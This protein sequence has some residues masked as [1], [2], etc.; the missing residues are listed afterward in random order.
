MGLQWYPH[1]PGD[2]QRD[3]KDLTL[4]EHGAYRQLL[5]YYYSTGPLPASYDQSSDPSLDIPDHHRLYRICGAITQQEQKAVDTVV[6]KYFKKDGVMYRNKKADQVIEERQK[7]IDAKRRAVE[8]REAKKKSRDK[9]SD[10]SH[11]QPHDASTTTT[12]TD[13]IIEVDKST[14]TANHLKDAVDIWND[15]AKKMGLSQVQK[16]T[17]QRK[18]KLNARL[19]SCGGLDG[20]RAAVEKASKSA[21][22]TGETGWRADFDFMLQ[23]KSFTKLMEGAYDNG[24]RKRTGS[25]GATRADQNRESLQNWVEQGGES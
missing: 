23:E 24:K 22:L 6:S 4:L 5:D 19:K 12:T 8:A 11:D 20:W 7:V 2:Y 21:F 3:T 17:D 18:S 13:S 10:A 15:M 9:S 1:Y 25:G 16:L 14:S